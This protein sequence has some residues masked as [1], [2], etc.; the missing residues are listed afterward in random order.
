M[1]RP[2][3]FQLEESI[4]TVWNSCTDQI[5]TSI[6]KEAQT[7]LEKQQIEQENELE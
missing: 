5:K 1:Q 3:V 4:S 7:N 6:I 2:I